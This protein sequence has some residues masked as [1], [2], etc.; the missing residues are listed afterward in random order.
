MNMIPR[1]SL[2]AVMLLTNCG[3][4][5]ETQPKA[6]SQAPTTRTLQ[7]RR[8]LVP[9]QY[10]QIQEAVDAA[11]S[12]DTILVSPGTYKEAVTIDKTGI[13]LRGE[14]RN[15]VILEGEF[16]KDN[17]IFIAADDVVVENLTVHG[18]T[19]NG[20]FITGDGDAD[21]PPGT[22]SA[23]TT[24]RHY[25]LSYVTAAN[26]GLYG[27]YA[28]GA[29]D[30]II[31]HSYA[32]G[33]PD[34]G[35]YI[36]QCSPCRTVV[37][38][39]AAEHNSIGM[40]TTNAG[41]DLSIIRSRFSN[42]RVGVSL[43]S[44]DQE[45]LAPQTGNTLIAGNIVE[46]NQDPNSPATTGGFGVGIA[47]AGGRENLVTKNLVLNHS[48]RGI[49]VTD[50]SNYAPQK[51]CIRENVL[52]ENAVD[53]SMGISE[54]ITY[55]GATNGFQSNTSTTEQPEGLVAAFPC[56]G[57]QTPVP[58]P[59][60]ISKTQPPSVSWKEIPAPAPQESMPNL[61]TGKRVPTTNQDTSVDLAAI[62]VP[63]R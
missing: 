43:T 12:G 22:D 34:S 6:P 60:Y 27:I 57:T 16:K 5:H 49:L 26:N 41:G 47:I 32:S 8:L 29:Q 2:L 53:L 35:I 40:Y 46:S 37:R 30:G 14:D 38:D 55:N 50:L 62:T 45:L 9:K 59:A 15:T 23:S 24:R 56:E 19:V 51:N 42:N 61:P 48:D 4:D 25:R 58:L 39:S 3:G 11:E 52:S 1:L 20:I 28:F 21:N 36:G 18:Y 44:Q 13:T 33:N 31:E 7:S 10:R 63:T 17:G 54:S